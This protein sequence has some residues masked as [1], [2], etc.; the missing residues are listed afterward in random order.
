MSTTM[1]DHYNFISWAY[2]PAVNSE[3]AHLIQHLL[4]FIG[5]GT[6]TPQSNHRWL[7]EFFTFEN[8][9][10]SVLFELMNLPTAKQL[11]K[12]AWQQSGDT[13]KLFTMAF[14]KEH[15]WL[16]RGQAVAAFSLGNTK[17]ADMV[18][19][20]LN[21]FWHPDLNEGGGLQAAFEATYSNL[22][23]ACTR[24]SLIF[25]IKEL[26]NIRRDVQGMATVCDVL[27][28]AKDSLQRDL[29]LFGG[30][31]GGEF[32]T[33]AVK[34]VAPQVC[35]SD[36]GSINF[37]LMHF[38]ARDKCGPGCWRTDYEDKFRAEIKQAFEAL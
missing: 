26:L 13:V 9:V 25:T 32:A 24:L 17:M 33:K 2:D 18:V 34:T 11:P 30:L 4:H 14:K 8:H 19:Q 36:G 31:L 5:E 23:R 29:L 35:Y 21:A 3:R 28:S 20:E 27:H 22:A 15:A 6:V 7:P 12:R 10:K 16:N 38:L 37:S 1:T